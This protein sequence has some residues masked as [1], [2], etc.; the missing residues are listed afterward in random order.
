[1][2]RYGE[3]EAVAREAGDEREERVDADRFRKEGHRRRLLRK[4]VA[5]PRL[6]CRHEHRTKGG[7]PLDERAGD[8]RSAPFRHVP[9]EKRHVK[10]E[11]LEKPIRLEQSG[12]AV[13][14]MTTPVVANGYALI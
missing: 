8:L 14:L 6:E 7:V 3:G 11:K 10:A 1:V 13:S 12:C 5:G 9:I 4:E 2:E